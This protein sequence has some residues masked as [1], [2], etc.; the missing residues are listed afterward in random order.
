KTIFIEMCHA[1]SENAQFTKAAERRDDLPCQAVGEPIKA[2]VTC[3][4]L[5][6]QDGYCWPGRGSPP[7]PDGLLRQHDH[8]SAARNGANKIASG[9]AEEPADVRDTLSERIFSDGH[10][11]PISR[12]QLIL[13]DDP[14]CVVYEMPEYFERSV[15]Q[16][17]AR[18][19]LSRNSSWRRSRVKS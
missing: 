16:I 1:S 5:E 6:G 17:N 4:R 2:A 8:V 18:L 13:G 11:G 10:A 19:V 15:P 9:H 12:Q 14:A 3:V 7:A